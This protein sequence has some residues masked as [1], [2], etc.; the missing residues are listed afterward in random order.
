M[1]AQ[2]RHVSL[3]AV[4]SWFFVLLQVLVFAI[5]VAF[6]YAMEQIKY[7]PGK[8]HFW[9]GVFWWGPLAGGLLLAR[10]LRS[11]WSKHPIWI[12]YSQVLL[13][14]LLLLQL[15][16]GLI[17]SGIWGYAFRRPSIFPEVKATASINNLAGVSTQGNYGT[18]GVV[19]A[20]IS[21]DKLRAQKSQPYYNHFSRFF[22]ALP[23]SQEHT[24]PIWHQM[25]NPNVAAL[26]SFKQTFDQVL[27]DEW[28]IDFGESNYRSEW[29][30]LGYVIDITTQEGQDYLYLAVKG[31]E[32]SNDHYP[33]YEFLFTKDLESITLQRRAKYYY[34]IAG[35]EG[36]EYSTLVPPISA[37]LAVG[38][39]VLFALHI[40]I[41]RM[42]ARNRECTL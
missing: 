15:F 19:C 10:S 29:G 33:F 31:R 11:R 34:D 25:G 18:E 41:F 5:G 22:L 16:A 21:L 2:S 4:S 38:L 9:Y 17:S 36:A 1:K 42:L 35:A 14:L 23:N 37:L 20:A 3:V 8:V 30:L 26:A 39:L 12:A 28:F 24:E 7:H 13:C 32:V 27:L 40:L 6:P